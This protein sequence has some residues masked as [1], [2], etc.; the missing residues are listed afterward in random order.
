MIDVSIYRP[1]ECVTRKAPREPIVG[2]NSI[3]VYNCSMTGVAV[4]IR[5]T[6]SYHTIDL[7]IEDIKKLSEI[8]AV[9]IKERPSRF[10]K[11]DPPTGEIDLIDLSEGGDGRVY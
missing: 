1:A 7:T 8:L 5:G 6:N 4:Q 2:Q 11:V 3:R 10:D 9:I